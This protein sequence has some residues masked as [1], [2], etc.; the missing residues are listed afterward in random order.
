VEGRT[1]NIK[2][3][4]NASLIKGLKKSLSSLLENMKLVVET[5]KDFSPNN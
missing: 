4:L 2:Y 5:I 1:L 3:H